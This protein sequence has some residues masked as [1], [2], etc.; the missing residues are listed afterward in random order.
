MTAQTKTFDSGLLD[1]IEKYV[2]TL[3][4]SILAYR[5]IAAYRVGGS[6]IGLIY[7]FD[8][9]IIIAFIL[10]R[11]STKS[12][13][14]RPWDWAVGF[15]GTFL[16]LLIGP[17]SAEWALVPAPVAGMIMLFGVAL[18]LSAKLTL[19][20]SFG[21]VAANRGVVAS[22]PYRFIRHPMYAGYFFV[23]L[24]LL[25]SGPNLQNVVFILAS[26][27]CFIWRIAA[28]ERLLREDPDY[29]ALMDRTPYRLV[30]GV[31]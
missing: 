5:M 17:S 27:M 20:R 28:E 30:P 13:T 25:A 1:Q 16:S 19:R 2:L 31:Y 7:L 9:F 18:H 8:Q 24:G 11:R 14:L 12:I 10:F 3:V 4:F 22:G 29:R 15:A 26:W 6:S 21:V 23:Q